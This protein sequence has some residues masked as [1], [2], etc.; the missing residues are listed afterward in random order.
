MAMVSGK[1]LVVANAGDCRA[2][3][4]KRGGIAVEMSTDHKPTTSAER[5]RIE[6][7]G[8]F[9]THD[10]YLNRMLAVSRALGDMYVKARSPLC[11]DP[12]VQQ[13]ELSEEDE[14]LVIAC[15]GL[16]DVMSSESAVAIARRE[17]MSSNDPERCSRVLVTEAL[18]R[19]AGDN[20]TVVVV[21]FSARPP[22][23]TPD[24]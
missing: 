14:F 10:G 22:R 4:G 18:S 1:S 3:L 8:G 13:V 21:C 17:L 23:S 5:S 20:L 15:D 7:Q 19:D 11:A 16:W 2:V 12:D 24:F 9:V 6:S